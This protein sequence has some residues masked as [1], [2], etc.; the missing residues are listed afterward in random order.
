MSLRPQA[1]A[2]IAA[3]VCGLM[4]AACALDKPAKGPEAPAEKKGKGTR[5]DGG[6]GPSGIQLEP[7]NDATGAVAIEGPDSERRRKHAVVAAQAAVEHASID[8][9][10]TMTSCESACGALRSMER[11]VAHLCELTRDAPDDA[12]RC[13]DAQRRLDVARSKVRATCTC[14]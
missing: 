6:D 1:P 12:N 9:D 13:A 7:Q 4:V 11:A 14:R 3:L 5:G 2:A 8:L 10:A